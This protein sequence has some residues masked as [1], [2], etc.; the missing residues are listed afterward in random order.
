MKLFLASLV[1]AAGLF[2]TGR[3]APTFLTSPRA[4]VLI[5]GGAMMNGDHF[6]DNTL[7]T[8]RAHYAGCRHIVMILH[9]S[10]PS[11]R[12]AV[13]ARMQ[14]AFAH[15]GVPVAESV[16]HRDDAGA[17]A[18][19]READGIWVGGGET[20]VVLAELYR[21]GQLAAIRERVLAG[22]P[23]GG[24]SAGANVAG[25]LIGTTNDFPTAEIPTRVA[26]AIFPA[27]I[28]PHHPVPE[29]KA[30]FDARAGKI[31]IYLRFN[32][33]ETVLGLGNAALVRLHDGK[34]ILTAGQAWLYRSSGVRAL[35]PGDELTE[36][37]TAAEAVTPFKPA[38]N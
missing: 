9:A 34:I 32:P 8:M 14:K 33:T 38:P 1:L 35:N 11:D 25:L 36:I 3:A 20:F 19:I 21:S 29:P 4:S 10:H 5:S 2:S 23:Y 13:E 22:I 30:D 27:V 18:L 16:H 7:P 28:N 26:L 17:L 24:A 6:S 37:E 12:D 15:L 31:R